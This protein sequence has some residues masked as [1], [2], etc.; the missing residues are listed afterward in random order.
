VWAVNNLLIS[1]GRLEDAGPGSYAG[2]A[3]AEWSELMQEQR[4]DYR[5]R[6][7]SKLIGSA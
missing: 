6:A 4:Q 7:G 5:L 1:K 3:H 2:N